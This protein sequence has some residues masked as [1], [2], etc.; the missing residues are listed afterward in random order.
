MAVSSFTLAIMPASAIPVY[1]LY[2]PLRER[3][4]A[5]PGIPYPLPSNEIPHSGQKGKAG[6]R[7]PGANA[8]EYAPQ[9]RVSDQATE[10]CSGRYFRGPLVLE[11]INMRS[12][13]LP[14]SRS[15]RGPLGQWPFGP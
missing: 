1:C 11:V 14:S 12:S 9:S 3:L 4:Y 2:Q 5:L 6:I 7:L 8:P 13:D 15:R 10:V